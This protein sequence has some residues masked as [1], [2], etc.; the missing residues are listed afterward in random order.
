MPVLDDLFSPDS[1]YL[2]FCFKQLPKCSRPYFGKASSHQKSTKIYRKNTRNILSRVMSMFTLVQLGFIDVVFHGIS[3][4][5]YFTWVLVK[6]LDYRRRQ[7]IR[8]W[9]KT[10]WSLDVFGLSDALRGPPQ[11]TEEEKTRTFFTFARGAGAYL[12]Q[13]NITTRA[14]Q[15]FFIFLYFCCFG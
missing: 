11:K 1:M 4:Q 2:L 7:T 15:T 13:E 14:F 12:H 5:R 3:F 8:H 6:L 9:M 10:I